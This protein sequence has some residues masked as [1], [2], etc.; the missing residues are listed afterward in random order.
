VE[1]LAETILLDCNFTSCLSASPLHPHFHVCLAYCIL[2]L[3]LILF[4][5]KLE[6]KAFLETAMLPVASNLSI[7]RVGTSASLRVFVDRLVL[8]D[9]LFL[10]GSPIVIL[11]VITVTGDLALL[12][13]LALGALGLGGGLLSGGLESGSVGRS[14]SAVGRGGGVELEELLLGDAQHFTS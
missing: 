13:G 1:L 12:G 4:V 14:N 3:L 2:P 10:D 6:P 9:S 7:V 11:A 8:D 5:Q